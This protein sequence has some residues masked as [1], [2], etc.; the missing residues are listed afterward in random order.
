MFQ[1]QSHL[2]EL[3][4]LHLPMEILRDD[5]IYPTMC[6]SKI[7]RGAETLAANLYPQAFA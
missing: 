4:D 1:W 3:H 5:L 6:D 7:C 2:K